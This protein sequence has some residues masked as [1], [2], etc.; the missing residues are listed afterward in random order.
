M[1]LVLGSGGV[2]VLAERSGDAAGVVEALQRRAL[3]PP[4]L[5]TPVLVECLRRDPRPDLEALAA[6]AR[7]VLIKVV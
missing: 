4:L 5:P 6:Y 2:S 3:W 1:A 7:D